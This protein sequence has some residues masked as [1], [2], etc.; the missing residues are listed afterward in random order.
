MIDYRIKPK[1]NFTERIGELVCMLEHSRE[2]TLS[3]I[4]NLKKS[5]L[6]YLINDSSNSIGALLSHITSIEFIH[7]IISFER[8]D[9]TNGE[10]QKWGTALELG[11]KARKV[12]RN[13]SIDYYLDELSQVR[14]NTLRY[15]KSKKDSWLFEENK[16]GN[17]VSYNNYYLWFH[18]M[19]DEINHRGQIR[20]I[21]RAIKK[22]E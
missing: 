5:D 15:M 8:R 13:H 1:E 19:E 12:I 17:G 2:V 16:W 9:L 6:D 20:E 14:Q 18:V 4:S 3:E 7:Q 21:K 22:G 10:F 11:D